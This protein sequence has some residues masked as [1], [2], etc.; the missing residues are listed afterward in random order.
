MNR[1]AAT[2]IRLWMILLMALS[3]SGGSAAAD[4]WISLGEKTVNDR[5]DHDSI[6]IGASQGRFTAVKIEVLGRAVHFKDMKIHYANGGV[7]D[8]EIRRV[9]PA[10]GESRAIDLTGD[11]RIVTRVEFWYE[12]ET[13]KRGKGSR[14][15]LLGRR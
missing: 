1:L 11:D 13:I 10:K 2:K 4:K 7:Q 12:A 9:I 14:I 6:R 5:L 8:V 3:I 15:R